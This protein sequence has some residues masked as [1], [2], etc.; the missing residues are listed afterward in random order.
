MLYLFEPNK[1]LTPHSPRRR[2]F[3]H[4]RVPYVHKTAAVEFWLNGFGAHRAAVA[5]AAAALAATICICSQFAL[6]SKGRGGTREFVRKLYPPGSLGPQPDLRPRFR[7]G[8]TSECVAQIADLYF[9][10]AVGHHAAA[11]A[12]GEFYVLK[13]P[14]R[15]MRQQFASFAAKEKGEIVECCLDDECHDGRR[16]RVTVDFFMVAE[17]TKKKGKRWRYSLQ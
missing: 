1:L 17:T 10:V 3:S 5:S 6:L 2:H 14:K 8:F 9:G 4:T 15:C 16:K 11:A 12:A 13:R 7:T